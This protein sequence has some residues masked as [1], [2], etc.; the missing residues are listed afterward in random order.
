M[1]DTS[2]SRAFV[3]LRYTLIVA[4]AYLIL[5]EESF[6]FPPAGTILLVV[7]AL[8]S[9]VVI[10]QLS[11]STTERVSFGVGIIMVDTLWVT[12]IL[13]QSGH[14]QADFFYLYFFILLLAA[15]GEHLGLIAV[16]AAATC[17]AYIY[18][19]AAAGNRWSLWNSPSLIRLPFLFTVAIFYGH[20]VGRTRQE[21][22]RAD[23]AADELRT[24]AQISAALVRVGR[25][26]ISSLD[27]P[28][29]LDRLCQ[30]TIEVLECDCSHTFLWQ[31]QGQ[32]YVP[33]SG[34]DDTP[35]QW[36]TIRALKIPR[37]AIAH[38]LSVLEQQEIV[39]LAAPAPAELSAALAM[40]HGSTA[41]LYMPL[42]RGHTIVG[43]QT[44][45]YR[46]QNARFC[47]RE[48]RIAQGIA[49]IASITLANA[50][51]FE[52]LA[53]ANRLKADFVATMSHEL[54]T[55]LG[56]IMGYNELL[57]DGTIGE[58]SAE[59]FQILKR[60]EASARELLDMIQATLDLSRLEAKKVDLQ[61]QDIHASSFLMDL[62][63]ETQGL[64]AHSG[65]AFKWEVAPDLT[66]IRTDPAK[67]KMVLQNLISNA[68]KFTNLGRVT[69]SVHQRDGGIEFSV[70]D[71]GIGIAPEM[72]E[73]IFEPFRQVEPSQT[74]SHNGA[75]LGLHI[76]QRL[77][78]LL[79]G[80][81]A[82]ESKV[83]Q[84]STFRVWIPFG[85]A[86]GAPANRWPDDIEKSEHHCSVLAKSN[87]SSL[88]PSGYRATK[89][90][91]A[92]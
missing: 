2:S 43:I 86:E 53:C 3:L 4:T 82:L 65:L 70:T 30:V 51:L 12:T 33:L 68:V 90:H 18:V 21:R 74:R 7:A 6:A 20:L 59:Q 42:R 19:L 36:E 77:L 39:E 87:G 61:L 9:N 49:Q 25:E 57:L 80:T 62:D 81:V 52:E 28:V 22:S 47:S 54:R 60:V 63:L 56:I 64:Q 67:L 15:I 23:A 79:G 10:A 40:V 26:M 78:E 38:L 1:N 41:C 24:E 11:P 46:G 34:C 5:A 32:V 71:T 91:L 66:T 35:E 50:K 85:V 75:G 17:A 13:L 27:T 29:I 16:G 69:V 8:A 83:G 31:P 44:A 89:S 84:G 55:P 48:K 37:A 92:C 72:H 45:G 58:L 73:I 88:L 14:F 76:V